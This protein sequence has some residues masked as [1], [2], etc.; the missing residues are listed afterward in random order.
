M[1]I[2]DCEVGMKVIRRKRGKTRALKE[3]GK[4]TIKR[5]YKNS[6]W[7]KENPGVK[8]LPKYFEPVNKFEVGDE[9]IYNCPNGI[10]YESIIFGIKDRQYA[11]KYTHKTIEHYDV[12]K[13]R[14]LSPLK[15]KDKLEVGDKFKAMDS[16]FEVVAVGEDSVIGTVYFSKSLGMETMY[17]TIHNE[18]IDKIIY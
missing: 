16:I 18:K 7:I 5:I 13:E 2:E 10:K 6:I 8:Y 17:Y 1:K 11:I 14:Q 15:K 9:V 3:G 12:V 4:Y